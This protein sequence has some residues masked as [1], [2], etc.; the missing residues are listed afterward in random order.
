MKKN[1]DTGW[2]TE[3]ISKQLSV[4]LKFWRGRNVADKENFCLEFEVLKY[5]IWEFLN[6]FFVI[7]IPFIFNLT[8]WKSSTENSTDTFNWA[9][10]KIINIA[11]LVSIFLNCLQLVS[12]YKK[13]ATIW[14]DLEHIFKDRLK[15]KSL[16]N[17]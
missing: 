15:I 12:L 17:I 2:H 4:I 11:H 3:L 5:A 16:L 13:S 14:T 9:I 7:F 8:F 6:I 10:P 1:T